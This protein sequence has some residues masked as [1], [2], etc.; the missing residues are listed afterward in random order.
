MQSF[1]RLCLL[2]GFL[3]A[4]LTAC[5]VPLT[6]SAD[7]SI[8]P[9][10]DSNCQ[11][12][13]A[14]NATNIDLVSDTDCQHTKDSTG[15]PVA[16]T[17]FCNATNFDLSF[18]YNYTYCSTTDAATW[19]VESD[20]LSSWCPV[21]MYEDDENK[22]FFYAT[23]RCTAD[24]TAESAPVGEAV[25]LAPFMAIKELLVERT[26]K[27]IDVLQVGWDKPPSQTQ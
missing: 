11:H 14:P 18:W 16:F 21:A 2:V 25:T 22:L 4:V 12:P 24:W 15:N 13:L 23:L 20:D 17:Y 9:F 26:Q 3:V 5:A 1:D 7:G 6:V 27:M 10:V 8:Q 19:H